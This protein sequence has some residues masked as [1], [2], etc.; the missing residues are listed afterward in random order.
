MKK[1]L[2]KKEIEE[3]ELADMIDDNL[4]PYEF[5]PKDTPKERRLKAKIQELKLELKLLMIVLLGG[6][7]WLFV[8]KIIGNS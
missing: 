6:I 3:L 8:A 1:K 2:T 7:I 4:N 5:S